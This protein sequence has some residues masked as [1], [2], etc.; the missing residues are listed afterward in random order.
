MYEDHRAVWRQFPPIFEATSV[1]IKFFLISLQL[2]PHFSTFFLMEG[3][4]KSS[5]RGGLNQKKIIREANWSMQNC[6]VI[7]GSTNLGDSDNGNSS[8]SLELPYLGNAEKPTSHLWIYG[9][10][11]SMRI[12]TLP[13]LRPRKLGGYSSENI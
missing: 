7:H 1:I 9:I 3:I 12:Q 10:L 4:H 6:C 13:K 2:I 5:G 8:L 11:R